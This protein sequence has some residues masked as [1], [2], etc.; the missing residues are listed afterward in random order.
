[1][2]DPAGKGGAGGGSCAPAGG[3]DAHQRVPHAARSFAFPKLIARYFKSLQ[4]PASTRT[5]PKLPPAP[6][7]EPPTLPRGSPGPSHEGDGPTAAGASRSPGRVGCVWIP[8]AACAAACARPSSQGA[9]QDLLLSC[10]RPPA[11]LPG[12]ALLIAAIWPAEARCLPTSSPAP[13]CPTS[14]S[15]LT[16]LQ[17]RSQ[18][19][20]APQSR[21]A[22]SVAAAKTGETSAQ[23]RGAAQT[24]PPSATPP[25]PSSLARPAAPSRPPI[26]VPAATASLPGATT[27]GAQ[28]TTRSSAR[29]SRWAPAAAPS[30]RIRAAIAARIATLTP[31]RGAREWRGRVR[32]SAGP[33]ASADRVWHGRRGPAGTSCCRRLHLTAPVGHAACQPPAGPTLRISASRPSPWARPAAP[34]ARIL[35]ATAAPT[36]RT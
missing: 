24:M 31:I 30:A 29:P 9:A 35:V 5:P 6:R 7:T 15:P 16:R 28:P 14:P 20:T 2:D 34:S 26:V 22:A 32:S 23:T 25:A 13:P 3:G 19:Q 8:P 4:S 36:R 18:A 33:L 10:T 11:R 17:P 1:M 27:T 12:G 21:P